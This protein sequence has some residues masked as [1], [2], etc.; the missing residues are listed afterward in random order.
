MTSHAETTLETIVSQLE[1]SYPDG[2]L[3][4]ERMEYGT[5]IGK[6][7]DFTYHAL[8]FTHAK[9]DRLSVKIDADAI[10]PYIDFVG[11][12]EHAGQIGLSIPAHGKLWFDRPIYFD[13]S[14]PI[15][16]HTYA[17]RRAELHA[18]FR[19]VLDLHALD[20]EGVEAV[21]FEAALNA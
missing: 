3:C 17:D 13:L 15:D 12:A 16:C 8:L 21:P 6:G 2:R 18:L 4:C 11:D 10:Y 20:H 19:F 14:V 9:G 5:S 1:A 7:P